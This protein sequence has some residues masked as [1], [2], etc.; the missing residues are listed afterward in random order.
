VYVS[1]GAE[2]AIYRVGGV[3]G[4]FDRWFE[5][6]RFASPQGLAF[7][8]DERYLF[9]ADYSYGI[10]RIGMKDRSMLLLPVPDD[11]AIMGIDGLDFYDGDLVVIQN[12]VRPHRVLRLTLAERMDRIT[13][14]ETLEANHPDFDEPT[15]GIVVPDPRRQSAVFYYV[16]NSHWGA[17]DREGKLR[18]NADLTPPIIL[19]LD[20]D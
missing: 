6:D 19:K 4:V 14:W 12:G 1:D 3:T 7:S 20:L 5:S 15:L 2:G 18:K 11:L 17:F 10:F 13:G 8:A 16:A 9:V